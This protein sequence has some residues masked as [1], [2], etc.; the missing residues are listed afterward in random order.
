M[1]GFLGYLEAVVVKHWLPLLMGVFGSLPWWARPMLSPKLQA[2]VD[3]YL[4]P[5]AIKWIGI[6]CII[7]SFIWA[8]YLAWKD[9]NNQNLAHSVKLEALTKPNLIGY[10]DSYVSGYSPE[11]NATQLFLSVSIK[12]SG[13]PSIAEHFSLSIGNDKIKVTH[14]LPTFIQDGLKLY[15]DEI[16]AEFHRSDALEEKT[17]VPIMKGDIKRGWLRFVL[18]DVKIDDIKRPGVITIQFDDYLGRSYSSDMK[19]GGEGQG[20]FYYPGGGTPFRIKPKPKQD[21]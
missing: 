16:Q 19:I 18:G 3:E 20:L 11:L 14:I 5:S 21:K 2:V 10:I 6:A 7:V 15:G 8:N 4:N 1:S 13:S 17:M 12:N 9:Q